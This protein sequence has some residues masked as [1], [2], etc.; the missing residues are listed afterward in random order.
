MRNIFS[1]L[2]LN[3]LCLL[4]TTNQYNLLALFI[5]THNSKPL[6]LLQP[7]SPKCAGNDLL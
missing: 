5:D 4:V 6:S 2:K 7:A 1:V 3:K